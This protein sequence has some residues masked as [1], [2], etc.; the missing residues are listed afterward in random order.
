MT[1]VDY[2][3]EFAFGLQQQ[4]ALRIPTVDAFVRE[5]Q[6]NTARGIPCVAIARADL[7]FELQRQHVH[8][9]ILAADSRRVII[10]NS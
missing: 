6:D 4:P 1:L 5:W 7:V 10:D 2:E 8:L 9:R 3:D